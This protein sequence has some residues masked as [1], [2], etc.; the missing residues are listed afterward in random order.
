MNLIGAG[1]ESLNWF[2]RVFCH[3]MDKNTYFH[4]LL[5]EALKRSDTGVRMTPHLAGDRTCVSNKTAAITGS[6]LSLR[7]EDILLALIKGL[8]KQLSDGMDDFAGIS[9]L[10]DTIFYTGG[11]AQA[12]LEPKTSVSP[13]PFCACPGLRHDWHRKTD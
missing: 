7:K 2:H 4:K 10:S 3:D 5:P 1:G 12:L 11:G 13:I 9:K 8:I 6:T